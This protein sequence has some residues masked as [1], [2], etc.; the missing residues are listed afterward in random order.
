MDDLENCLTACF[1]TVFPK[2]QEVEVTLASMVTFK[3]WGSLRMITLVVVIEKEFEV[4]VPVD[5]IENDILPNPA[6]STLRIVSGLLLRG[7]D[8]LLR[9]DLPLFQTWLC[10]FSHIILSSIALHCTTKLF[11]T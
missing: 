7:L 4:T 11:V 8:G 10:D 9:N 6:R 2:L 5:K 3:E 1:I